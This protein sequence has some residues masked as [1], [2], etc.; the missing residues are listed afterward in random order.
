MK[1]RVGMA[2]ARVAGQTR[3]FGRD[4]RPLGKREQ[5]V[6]IGESFGFFH[7]RVKREMIHY[8]FQ[9]G[10]TLCNAVDERQ[11]SRRYYHHDRQAGFF[12]F[13]PYPVNAALI[14]RRLEFRSC[15]SE[16]QSEHT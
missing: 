10:M 6:Q 9:I 1:A 8:E 12:R 13:G 14:E 11:L 16:T 4:V 2:V 5:F 3:R 15:E 7:A